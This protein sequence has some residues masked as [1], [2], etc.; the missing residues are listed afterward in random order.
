MTAKELADFL[1]RADSTT[2]K[3][4]LLGDV[5]GGFRRPLL[6][7]HDILIFTRLSAGNDLELHLQVCEKGSKDPSGGPLNVLGE[8]KLLLK[9]ANSINVDRNF[10]L[11]EGFVAQAYGRTLAFGKTGDRVLYEGH[12]LGDP[13]GTPDESGEGDPTIPPR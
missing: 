3:A 2:E 7:R 1:V 5:A 11:A 13:H 8:P 4:W 9:F 10:T 12:Y 6:K